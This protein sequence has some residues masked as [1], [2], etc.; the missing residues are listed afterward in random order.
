MADKPVLVLKD[1]NPRLFGLV[2]ELSIVQVIF[3]QFSKKKENLHIV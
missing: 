1:L 2:E 3:I